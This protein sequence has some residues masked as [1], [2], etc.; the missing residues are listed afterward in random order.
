MANL[1][2]ILI[3]PYFGTFPEWMDKFEVPKG[4]DWFLDTD[5]D[6]FKKRVKDKL[7]IDYPGTYGSGKV[8]DYRCAL[9]LLYEEEIKGFDFWG[10]VDFDVV[11]GDVNK[12]FPD[13]ELTKLDI[14][15]N[16]DSYVCGFWSLYRN[17]KD[18]N[19]LFM[20]YPFWE[21]KLSTPDCLGWVEQ[22]YS[23]LLEQSGLRY[24]YSMF[25]GDPYHPPFNLK[26][27]DGKLYQDGVE[28]AMLHFRRDKKWPL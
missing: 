20:K 14:W 1:K 2:K 8:W 28:I 7:G 17:C 26:K 27:E 16:H 24:K 15:S 12:F 21:D 11:F 13:E 4:Y 23:K 22:Q 18:V 9:G 6:A 19:E 5:L 25:Q 3:T 10:T